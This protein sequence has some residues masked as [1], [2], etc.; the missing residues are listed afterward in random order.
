MIA[1]SLASGSARA[2]ELNWPRVSA[3]SGS[4]SLHLLLA[5]A[6]LIP[7]VAM[8]MRH[9]TQEPP[10]LLEIHAQALETA[11][12]PAM[13]VPPM[14]RHE[15][16]KPQVPVITITQP[17]PPALPAPV[18]SI[19]TQPVASANEPTAIPGGT[20]DQI[21]SDAEPSAL[22]YG[23]RTHVPYPTDALRRHE[24][25]KVVLR[26]L[27]GTDGIPQQIEIDRSSGSRSLDNAAREAV[28]RW[29]F[30]PGMRSGVAYAAWAFVPISF[31]LPQ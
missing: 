29:T 28:R 9:L 10:I 19:D 11:P 26:I 6:L 18:A 16:T 8:Q 7:P 3:Y 13:P 25:G 5:L 24:Q 27:V 15:V 23:N 2:I 1:L 22:A 30:K 12:E 31:T 14:R 21:G 20:S 17:V 4:F